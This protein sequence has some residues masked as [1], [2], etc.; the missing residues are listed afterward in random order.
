MLIEGGFDDLFNETY[1][2]RMEQ[3]LDEIEEGKLK[4]TDALHEFYD[5]FKKDLAEFQKYAKTSKKKKRRPR[6]F[7]SS[8]TR[9][10]WSRSSAALANI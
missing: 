9:R 4:W 1:T 5:K 8:A 10:G 7:V 3:E 6:K 2:A